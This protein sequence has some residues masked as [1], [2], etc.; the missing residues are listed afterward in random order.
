MRDDGDLV[1]ASDGGEDRPD[2]GVG[3]R[4]LRSAARSSSRGGERRGEDGHLVSHRRLGRCQE[5]HAGSLVV[6]V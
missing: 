6:R 5:L 2:L 4:A 3:E 1:L